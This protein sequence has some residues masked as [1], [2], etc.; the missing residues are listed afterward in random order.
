MTLYTQEWKN[1]YAESVSHR[2]CL[3]FVCLDLTEL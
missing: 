1:V 3:M 2:V